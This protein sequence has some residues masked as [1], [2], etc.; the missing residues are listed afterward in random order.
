M[1]VANTEFF[2]VRANKSSPS[3]IIS[4]LV[5]FTLISS[6]FVRV[7]V[8]DGTELSEG[9]RLFVEDE[10]RGSFVDVLEGREDVREVLKVLVTP[11]FH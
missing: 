6:I 3:C 10:T 4:A 8:R 11:F 1:F 2:L 7:A 9:A 5:I